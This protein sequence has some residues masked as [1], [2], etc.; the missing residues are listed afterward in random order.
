M[1]RGA[2]NSATSSSRRIIFLMRAS[3]SSCVL[4]SSC[5]SEIA[6]EVITAVAAFVIRSKL[7]NAYFLQRCVNGFFVYYSHETFLASNHALFSSTVEA[8]G[9]SEAVFSITRLRRY[10]AVSFLF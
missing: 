6:S 1:K 10:A 5:A 2:P 8:W 4:K 9:S 3:G 7:A